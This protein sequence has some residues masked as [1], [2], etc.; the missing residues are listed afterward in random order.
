MPKAAT[1]F[2]HGWAFEGSHLQEGS[3]PG[4]HAL[5]GVME[6]SIDYKQK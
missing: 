3:I 4:V 1:S 5:K 2:L 6:D